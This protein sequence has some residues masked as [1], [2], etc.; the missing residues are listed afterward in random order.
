MRY[1][2]FTTFEMLVVIG[3][4]GLISLITIPLYVNYQ[5]STKLQSEARILATNLRLAQQLAITEQN[6]FNVKLLPFTGTYQI[7]RDKTSEIIKEVELDSEVSI[8]QID[9]LTNNTVQYNPTGAAFETGFV[10]L[11]NTRNETSTIEIKPSGYVSIS[12]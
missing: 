5:K 11:I 4:I 10:Y 1:K 12:E 2:G 7:I 9:D 6:I 3:I 8:N